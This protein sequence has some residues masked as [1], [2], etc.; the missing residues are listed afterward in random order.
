[1]GSFFTHIQ[2]QGDQLDAIERVLTEAARADGMRKAEASEKPDRQVV[3]VQSP[4]W[5][6]VYDQATDDQDDKLL[7]K[8]TRA[9]SRATGGSAFWAMVHDSDVLMLGLA[10]AGKEVDTYNSDPGS[11]GG[12]KKRGRPGPHIRAWSGLL[13]AGHG[14][15]ELDAVFASEDLFAEDA[16]GALAD[17]VG[18][19]RERALVGYRYLPDAGV[20]SGAVTLSFRL[21]QRPEWEAAAAGPTRLLTQ[22]EHAAEQSGVVYDIPEGAPV[23]VAVGGEARLSAGTVNA[24]APSTGLRVEV[25]GGA[26]CVTWEQVQ[27]VLGNPRDRRL[28]LAPLTEEG[29]IWVA[30]FPDAALPAGVAPARPSMNPRAL[31]AAMSMRAGATVHANALGRGCAVGLAEV[32]IRLVPTEHP[33]GATA[34][35]AAV[36]VVSTEDRPLRAAPDVHPKMLEA[37]RQPIRAVALV[38]LAP[39]SLEEA[40]GSLVAAME[41]HVPTAGNVTA[42]I[43]PAP[44]GG[45]VLGAL[46]GALKRPKISTGKAKGFLRGRRWKKLLGGLEAGSHISATWSRRDEVGA[47]EAQLE[48]GRGIL[49]SPNAQPAISVALSGDLD[50]AEDALEAWVDGLVT[51]GAVVQGLVTRWGTAPSVEMSPYE[52]A[53]GVSGQCTL[54]R[55]WVERWVRAVGRG[56][57]WLGPKVRAHVDEGELGA[58]AEVREQGE[59][60]RVEVED[61]A[62]VERALE[63]ALPGREDWQAGLQARYRPS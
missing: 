57:L 14:G 63:G 60:L 23:Q 33:D 58:V 46:M 50:A 59:A 13:A 53:A 43:Y 29:G 21:E 24:G 30:S 36:Q 2:V 51:A 25:T 48:A 31:M 1:M 52:V 15:D 42:A 54:E 39:D 20:P 16:L 7:S 44:M 5:V 17:A 47:S 9:L 37:L 62:A 45:G 38:I 11:F 55:S 56:T 4:G 26:E 8:L 19:P 27:L 18:L 61:V 6:S 34:V 35:R 28:L 49:P 40:V 22:W 41:P 32:T 3:L 12:R 10:H